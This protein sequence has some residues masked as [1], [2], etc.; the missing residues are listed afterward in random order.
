MKKIYLH[1]SFMND[2]FGDYLLFKRVSEWIYEQNKDNTILSCNTSS[3]YDGLVEFERKS[4][5]DCIK[6]A[7]LIVLCGGGYLGEPNS[8]KII[9][10]YNFI[11]NHGAQFRRIRKS[12]KP[13][14]IV[15]VGAGPQSIFITRWF[16]KIMCNGAESISVRDVES[17]QFLKSI[18]VNKEINMIP[19]IVMS[20]NDEF[21]NEKQCDINEVIDLEPN[22]K[23]VL[24][25]LT[26]RVSIENELIVNDIKKFSEENKD[27]QFIISS[28]QGREVIKKRNEFWVNKL[29]ENDVKVYNYKNP[30]ELLEIIKNSDLIITDKLHVGI[31]GT[32]FYKKVISVAGHSKIKRFYNQLGRGNNSKNNKEILQGE[33]YNL[34]SNIELED[35]NEVKNIRNLASKNK[36]IVTSF[37][38]K[39]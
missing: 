18:G 6:D 34:L 7:D 38:N 5:K 29:N 15:G 14:I 20:L 25:H 23:N 31:V 9:W 4:K 8:N 21:I 30:N 2:N 24:I 16:T 35:V 11:K 27:M 3:A 17:Q 32:R 19:D 1:G 22:K 37:I 10:A 39:Y 33:L 12:K 13:Y 28:D 26:S 36:D